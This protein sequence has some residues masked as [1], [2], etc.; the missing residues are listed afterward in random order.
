M[1]PKQCQENSWSRICSL[2]VNEL[3]LFA[4]VPSY[5]A[6]MALIQDEQAD[7]GELHAL[8]VLF[9]SLQGI[10]Q[11]LGSH[12]QDVFLFKQVQQ[13]ADVTHL[14]AQTQDAF[15]VDVLL[16]HVTLLLDKWHLTYRI[17]LESPIQL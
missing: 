15:A 17:N 8:V 16:E 12:D 14:P 5:L 2:I 6:V 11:D 4:L 13:R 3:A 1:L 7:L 10:D 9:A